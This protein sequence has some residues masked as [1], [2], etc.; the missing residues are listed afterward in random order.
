MTR[1]A[2]ARGRIEHDL[3]R[4][5]LVEAAAGTGKTTALVGRIARLVATGRAELTQI[6]AIT[7]TERAS[8][9]LML[10][11]R[12]RLELS[13]Q[14]ATDPRE[15]ERLE[16]ALGDFEAAYV[17][18]IH[19]FCAELLR[20]RPLEA[21]VDPSFTL[22]GEDEQRSLLDETTDRFL[23]D[24]LRDP[25]EGLRR[26]LARLRDGDRDRDPPRTVLAAEVRALV[27]HR[28]QDPRLE[29]APF[30]R[31]AAIDA[32]A[33]RADLAK[34]LGPYLAA[35]R[36]RPRDH[37]ALERELVALLRNRS[38]PKK[39]L[40]HGAVDELA[41]RADSDLAYCLA[42][43]LAPA[44]QRYEARKRALGVLDHLDSLLA[45][46]A[47][48]R[49][50][51]EA[52]VALRERF[53][54]LFVDEVQDVDPIQT[55]IVM[56]LADPDPEVADP[57]SSRPRPGS[58]YLVGDPKQAIY[59][60]RRAD[61]RTYL[62]L[63]RALVPA[64]A[65]LL[66]LGASF[67]PRPA[68]AALVNHAFATTFDGSDVQ[69]EDVPLEAQRPAM[70]AF[71][72]VV[73]LPSPR[74]LSERGNVT[75]DAVDGAMP[76][77]IASFVRWLLDESGLEVEDPVTRRAVP[78]AP[79]HVAILFRT[80]RD[81]GA[82]QARALERHGVPHS[83]VAPEAFFEREV[84]VAAS[85]LAS[86][87]EW[88]DDALA[89]YATLRGPFL[90]IPDADL[91]AYRDTIGP[92]HPLV[93]AD[94]K[95]VS[96]ERALVADALAL[97]RDLHRR[98][99]VTAIESTFDA[100]FERCEADVMLLLA[101][102]RGE[103]RALDQLRQL[104]RR[105]DRRG[106]SF[107]DLARWLAERV[108]DPSLGGVDV[109]ADTERM[110]AVSIL[111]VHGAKGLE[112]P[113]VVLG[114]PTSRP[115]RWQR[116]ASRYTDPER[117][118]VV[119]E[120]A[121]FAPLELRQ[122]H[123]VA[124]AVERAESARLLYVAATRAR[125]VLVVPTVGTGEIDDSWMAPLARAL[126]PADPRG[127]VTALSALPAFGDRSALDG[128]EARPGVR[129]GHHA[130]HLG[131]VTWWDPQHLL[132]PIPPR[133]TRGL[134]HLVEKVDG[135]STRAA[136]DAFEIERVRTIERAKLGALEVSAARR[137]AR[138]PAGAMLATSVTEV[139]L[140]PAGGAGARFVRLLRRLVVEREPADLA[141]TFARE[142][143]ASDAERDAALEAVGRF[144]A[145]PTL[146]PLLSHPTARA[147]VPYVIAT[148]AGPVAWGRVP[149]IVAAGADLT[150]VAIAVGEERESARIEA[151][152]AAS[153]LERSENRSVRVLLAC[154]DP[155]TRTL[156]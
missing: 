78:I 30:D 55:D 85:A 15:R 113:V 43:D 54:F 156:G 138:T 100:F 68:I 26:A 154:F 29:R 155:A 99:H 27:E 73:A 13:R 105:A 136:E 59:G 6:A 103:A 79:R 134:T 121:G 104:A 12:E 93:Q 45:A 139:P 36:T 49:S 33:K 3:D 118:A 83:F 150:V 128:G 42:R 20:A 66:E 147:D 88:P 94:A 89:V 61:L 129:P 41:A 51:R 98:R 75:R 142:L 47:L 71:P 111:T 76:D 53:R 57:A 133:E 69:A 145:E 114:D 62:A 1:D 117:N 64:H 92:L 80:M 23:E 132:R 56:L 130:T 143:A 9:E 131:G 120:I 58:L 153:A 22:L 125:D 135:R 37:D 107:R 82:R 7:F 31:V 21:G 101:E 84:V 97:L 2:D 65:E 149:W 108:E 17:G 112:M 24:A 60:F 74:A 119:R 25:P 115:Q 140:G 87:I 46:R 116:S 10:R 106:L 122:R 151:S 95:G 52:R 8:G 91:L 146:A 44:V 28:D 141:R 40:L 32:L 90:G 19:G 148:D 5:F 34:W 109:A 81:R 86:A 124:D 39:G 16:R 70:T 102:R 77:A 4:S 137:L 123:G 72:S 110:D 126:V 63:K 35:E 11:L 127:A 96:D 38:F 144:R 14:S 48:L 50:H 152:I 67:R 18:T